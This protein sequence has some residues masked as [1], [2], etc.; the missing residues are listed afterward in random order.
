MSVRPSVLVLGG[1]PDAE[2]EV[3]LVSARSVAD[4][5]QAAG[6]IVHRRT[7]DRPTAADLRAMIGDV[8]FPVLH[9]PWG[10]G[11][12][13]QDLLDADGRPY[14][15][16]RP[17]AARLAMDKIATKLVS[18]RSGVRTAAAAVLNTLDDQPPLPLPLVVKPV[19]EGS[20]VGVYIC[21]TPAD[22]ARA[23]DA[24]RAARA[25][26]PARV[27][28][29]ETAILDGKR[30]LT[31]GVLDG[32]ALSPIEIVP[33]V[34][35]Y[36][37]QAKYQRND[38][39]YVVGPALPP[40]VEDQLRA[41]AVTLARALGVRHLCRVDFL[42]DAHGVPWMLEVNTMPGFTEHSLLPMA[43]AAGRPASVEGGAVG[44][45]DPMPMPALCSWLV[46]LAVRDHARH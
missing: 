24:V 21:R 43:A 30:E 42:L 8:V 41:S 44:G 25:E 12:P 18:A 11:G 9:G 34:E 15:G 14:V 38:T 33:A 17:Q 39:R 23:I 3:S 37:Y 4:A 2:R 19:H 13:M 7:I 31:V 10:E 26:H 46:S 22:W 5:L 28:M 45:R 20:S 6:H 36:D 16:C 40:G 27:S 29:A 1:G 32:V 35:F